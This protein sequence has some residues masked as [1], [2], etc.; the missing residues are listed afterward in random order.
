MRRTILA[1]V[2]LLSAC[3]EDEARGAFAGYAEGEYLRV[4]VYQRRS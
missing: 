4:N 2:L 3:R 1:L